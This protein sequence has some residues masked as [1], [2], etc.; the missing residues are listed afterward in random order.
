MHDPLEGRLAPKLLIS[1]GM[2]QLE[3]QG[4]AGYWKERNIPALARW[5]TASFVEWFGLGKRFARCNFVGGVTHYH[6]SEGRF[7]CT[8]SAHNGMDFAT[9]NGKA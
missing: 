8:V 9:V 2:C 6:I 1:S 7:S 5:K 4:S 3:H